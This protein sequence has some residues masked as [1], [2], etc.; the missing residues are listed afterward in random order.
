MLIGDVD[1]FARTTHNPDPGL[2]HIYHLDHISKLI[3]AQSIIGRDEELITSI[4]LCFRQSD[5]L[6]I[7]IDKLIPYTAIMLELEGLIVITIS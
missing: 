3:A 7:R 2:L 6:L 4:W 5:N 1:I